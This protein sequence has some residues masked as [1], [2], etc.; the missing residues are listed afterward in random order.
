MDPAMHRTFGPSRAHEPLVA[1]ERER[2]RVI[3]LVI[4]ADAGRGRRLNDPRQIPAA[5]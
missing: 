2:N 4:H 5:A 3:P 1:T